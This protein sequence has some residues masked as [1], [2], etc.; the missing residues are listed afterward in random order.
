MAEGQVGRGLLE[1]GL[2][3]SLAAGIGDRR[4]PAGARPPQRANANGITAQR[5][6]RRDRHPGPDGGPAGRSRPPTASTNR[7]ATSTPGTR[8]PP[9]SA[10][11]LWPASQPRAK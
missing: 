11:Y 3:R 7:N 5:H 6:E 4:R 9:Y 8:A 1:L 10:K 2:G